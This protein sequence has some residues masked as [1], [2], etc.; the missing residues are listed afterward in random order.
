MALAQMRINFFSQPP[1]YS[2]RGHNPLPVLWLGGLG[3]TI[4]CPWSRGSGTNG[5][6]LPVGLGGSSPASQ[7][8]STVCQSLP[9]ATGA[10]LTV[11]LLPTMHSSCRARLSIT[12]VR[13]RSDTNPM[14]PSALLLTMLITTTSNSRPCAE[15]AVR[16]RPLC[17]ID[18]HE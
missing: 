2:T 6:S 4:L 7:Y 9:S 3:T 17:K 12:H 16:M 8:R 11:L 14:D 10:D 5:I 1:E 13:W 18:M 15:S